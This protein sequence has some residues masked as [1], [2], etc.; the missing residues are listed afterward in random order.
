MSSPA[1]EQTAP[2]PL[3]QEKPWVN[4]LYAWFVVIVLTLDIRL[5]HKRAA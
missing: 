1:L 2:A 5:L 3:T 4:P